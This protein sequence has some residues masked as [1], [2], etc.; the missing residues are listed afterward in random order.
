MPSDGEQDLWGSW[1]RFEFQPLFFL[2]VFFCKGL[3][4]R[5]AAA[6]VSGLVEKVTSASV[7]L[8]LT[9]ISVLINLCFGCILEISRVMISLGPLL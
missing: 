4:G 3:I 5:K 6:K 1:H 2:K 7:K 9:E 8:Y